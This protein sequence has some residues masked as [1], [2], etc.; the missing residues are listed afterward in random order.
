MVFAVL[1]GSEFP[2]YAKSAVTHCFGFCGTSGIARCP[3]AG[4]ILLSGRD[5][6]TGSVGRQVCPPR[7]KQRCITSRDTV[8][9]YRREIPWLFMTVHPFEA[10]PRVRDTL[11]GIEM[12]DVAEDLTYLMVTV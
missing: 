7:W 5:I 6:H 11:L 10:V 8:A 2:C 3:Y 4:V 9:R 1:R 12:D